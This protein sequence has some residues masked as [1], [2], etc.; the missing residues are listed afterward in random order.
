M[1][2]CWHLSLPFILMQVIIKCK[3][4]KAERYLPSE[5]IVFLNSSVSIDILSLACNYVKFNVFKLKQTNKNSISSFKTASHSL[6]LTLVNECLT[7]TLCPIVRCTNVFLT[8]YS[9][10]QILVISQ[11]KTTLLTLLKPEI[12]RELFVK[13]YLLLSV[14]CFESF[15]RF[16]VCGLKA[17]ILNGLSMTFLFLPIS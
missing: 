9:Y 3:R 11:M 14:F 2:I 15:Q 17:K 10:S 5:K 1:Q 13:L 6:Y 12:L 8:L 4:R 16:I 7:P